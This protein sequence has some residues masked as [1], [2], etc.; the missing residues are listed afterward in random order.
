MHDRVA[1]APC[2]PEVEQWRAVRTL[3][4]NRQQRACPASRKLAAGR[5]APDLVKDV[6]NRDGNVPRQEIEREVD[7]E[8][9]HE[10]QSG[11]EARSLRSTNCGQTLVRQRP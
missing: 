5:G 10:T 6:Q 3:G 4:V 2:P 8:L 1:T 7:R 11:N 9:R